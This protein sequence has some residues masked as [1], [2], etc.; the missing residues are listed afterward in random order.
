MNTILIGFYDEKK[1]WEAKRKLWDFAE[2]VGNITAPR[3]I[4]HKSDGKKRLDEDDT[5]NMLFILDKAKIFLP[6]YLAEN[7]EKIPKFKADK[8]DIFALMTTASNMRE[9]LDK[10]GKELTDI[11]T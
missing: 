4:T 10:L 7:P 9:W 2:Q 1:I 11:R 8:V 5:L 3:C 6:R